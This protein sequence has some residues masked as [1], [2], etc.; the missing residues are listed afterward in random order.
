MNLARPSRY[1]SCHQRLMNFKVYCIKAFFFFLLCLK[2]FLLKSHKMF[3]NSHILESDKQIHSIHCTQAFHFLIDILSYSFLDLVIINGSLHFL[4]WSFSLILSF[5]LFLF[6]Y[7]CLFIEVLHPETVS[8]NGLPL[9]STRVVIIWL[10]LPLSKLHP[11][12]A[13]G[14]NQNDLNVNTIVFEPRFSFK[15]AGKMF[16]KQVQKE[17]S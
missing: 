2:L 1:Y 14:S 15:A 9:S 7:F 4:S 12:Y 13:L 16:N 11:K 3:S 17:E 6:M 10:P 8:T 5:R